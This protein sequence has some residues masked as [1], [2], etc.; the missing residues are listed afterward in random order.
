MKLLKS[1][2]DNL[3][4]YIKVYKEY[5][6]SEEY[7]RDILE[8]E[9]RKKF[10]Q[11]FTAAKIKK[12]DEYEFTQFIGKLW[13]S[14]MFTNKEY[15]VKM[16]IASNGFDKLKEELINLLYGKKEPEKSMKIF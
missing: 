16:I 11:G 12:M 15:R 8:R 13:A 6:K 5:S 7:K 3:E 10:Y 2:L 1:Q 14:E 9:E 4:K